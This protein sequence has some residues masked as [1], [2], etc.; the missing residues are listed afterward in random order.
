MKNESIIYDGNIKLIDRNILSIRNNYLFAK[1][2]Y[3]YMGLIE[4]IL[5]N[6]YEPLTKPVILGSCGIVKIIE[7]PSGLSSELSGKNA[8]VS[9]NGAHGILSL[10]NDGLA[11]NYIQL[12]RSYIYK[13]ITDIKPYYTIYPYIAYSLT[14]CREVENPVLLIGCNILSVSQALYLKNIGLDSPDIVCSKIP[15][16]MKKY[17]LK[18]LQHTGDLL[19]KY[20]TIIVNY[21]KYSLIYDIINSIDH[22]KLVLTNLSRLK[23]IPVRRNMNTR[24]IYINNI[25]D[26]DENDVEKIT[27]DILVDIKIVKAKSLSE[28]IGLLPPKRFGLVIELTS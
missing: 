14:I 23:I 7:D 12:H 18:I 26:I 27:K 11:S 15:N 5:L 28:V 8:I 13:F 17:G 22:K 6:N 9:F 24:V 25:G 10:E 1:S 19:P 4:R 21:E 3:I 16:F 2:L 20:N